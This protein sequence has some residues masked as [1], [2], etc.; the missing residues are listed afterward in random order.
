MNSAHGNR[1]RRLLTLLTLAPLGV[2]LLAGC[3]R[4]TPGAPLSTPAVRGPGRPAPV[5]TLV[6]TVSPRTGLQPSGQTVTGQVTLTTSSSAYSS[7][8]PLVVTIHNG[9]STPI[10]AADHQS[11]CT[12]LTLQIW[13]K[14]AW[15]P[16]S[17]CEL[18]TETH[19]VS[20]AAGSATPVQLGFTDATGRPEGLAAGAYRALLTYTLGPFILSS[21]GSSVTVETETFTL[22]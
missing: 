22:A 14:G 7:G 19:E 17:R 18:M 21:P 15:T 5:S 16:V 12:V 9:L 13:S 4:P 6:S 2:M 10:G 20:F 8:N 3:A 1:C 11:N